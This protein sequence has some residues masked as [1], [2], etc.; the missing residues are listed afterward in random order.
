MQ[1]NLAAISEIGSEFP[2]QKDPDFHSIAKLIALSQGDRIRRRKKR[3]R[4]D[5]YFRTKGIDPKSSL[6]KRI[7]EK[8][9]ADLKKADE[10]DDRAVRDA[11]HQA[12]H[13]YGYA[14]QARDRPTE[15]L[16]IARKLFAR[17]ERVEKRF[18][19]DEKIVSCEQ[20]LM[21]CKK[22]KEWG[23]GCSSCK[24]VDCVQCAALTQHEQEEPRTEPE[25]A[26]KKSRHRKFWLQVK[27]VMTP[28]EWRKMWATGQVGEEALAIIREILIEVDP[29]EEASLMRSM[30]QRRKEY[31]E[32]RKRNQ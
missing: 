19:A 25:R 10:L 32:R 26:A 14:V 7:S 24:K 4:H 8:L 28:D 5:F 20:C 21:I 30:R 18:D 3:L 22:C 29:R 9:K 16:D 12:T 17:G 6:Y 27:E 2:I 1:Q 13:E 23:A 15:A 31:D 11:W